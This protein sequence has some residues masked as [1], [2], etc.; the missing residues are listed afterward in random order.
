MLKAAFFPSRLAF[1]ASVLFLHG[2]STAQ[3][4]QTG[5]AAAP[6]AP[7]ALQAPATVEA[8][9]PMAHPAQ[10]GEASAKGAP[11][12]ANARAGNATP[13]PNKLGQQVSTPVPVVMPSV[14]ANAD[15]PTEGI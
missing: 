11:A 9:R 10:E 1:A 5:P 12:D 15:G 14:N 6:A 7:P 2:A 8:V 4:I 3:V 13:P